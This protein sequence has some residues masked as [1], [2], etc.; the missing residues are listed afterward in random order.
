M[1]TNGALTYTL[2]FAELGMKN[3]A[4]ADEKRRLSKEAA[5][6]REKQLSRAKSRSL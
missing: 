2:D 3:I 1:K 6:P 5:P 4:S